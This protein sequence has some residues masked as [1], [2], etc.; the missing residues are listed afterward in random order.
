MERRNNEFSYVADGSGFGG[1]VRRL[2]SQS[3]NIPERES[4]EETQA[5][6]SQ[7]ITIYSN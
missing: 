7:M 6:I 3:V 5:L 2:E 4:L 1:E